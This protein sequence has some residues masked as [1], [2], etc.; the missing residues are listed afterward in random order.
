MRVYVRVDPGL[1]RVAGSPDD[2]R[3]IRQA[4]KRWQENPVPEIGT[5]SSA[6]SL[7]LLIGVTLG[8]P[9]AAGCAEPPTYHRDVAPIL[10]KNCQEC[11]RPGQVA[12]FSLLD[13]AQARKRA[14]DIAA[15]TEERAMPPWHASTTEG[16]PFRGAA[17]ADRCGI[18]DARRLGRRRVSGGRREGQPTASGV[19]LRVDAGTAGPGPQDVRALQAGADRGG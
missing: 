13:Y 18:E 19:D 6:R 7:A 1:C 4:Q 9:F 5:I 12:P 17:G 8:M 16:G 11:H 3:R 14:Q 2:S 15:V 10:Q